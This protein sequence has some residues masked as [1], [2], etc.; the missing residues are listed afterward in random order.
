MSTYLIR[1]ILVVGT[2]AGFVLQSCK[3]VKQQDDQL[4]SRHLQRQ[5]KLT[6]I[7]TPVSDDKTELNLII[8]ND[9][10]LLDDMGMKEIV[11]DSYSNKNINDVVIVGIHAGNRTQ[12]YGISDNAKAGGA[13]E[14]ADHYLSFV[15]NELYPYVKKKV[16]VR[17]F[18]T[19]TIAGFGA[20]ALSALDIA[21]EYPDKI[22]KVGMFSGAFSRKAVND[23]SANGAMYSKLKPSRKRP[24]TQ[25]WF[26]AGK[27]GNTDIKNDDATDIEINA[28]NIVQLLGSK[29]FINADDIIYKKGNANNMKAWKAVMPDFL[30]WAIGK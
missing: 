26:Y 20:S 22:S 4:Y 27:T 21:W 12:E 11:A 18:N 16:G 14:K 8:F 25:F 23:T 10:Q 2:I 19:V 3:K 9:G 29:N 30:E 28:N 7:N 24:K 13:G 15:N 17:K 5:V 6:I 1:T